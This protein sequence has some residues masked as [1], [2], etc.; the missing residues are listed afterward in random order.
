MSLIVDCIGGSRAGIGDVS[1][2]SSTR[3]QRTSSVKGK[4]RRRENE[5]KCPQHPL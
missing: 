3:G 1:E 5:T 4:H 2:G